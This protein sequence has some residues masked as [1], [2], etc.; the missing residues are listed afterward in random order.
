MPGYKVEITIPDFILA[1]SDGIALPGI[2][3]SRSHHEAMQKASSL[4]PGEYKLT[5]P[6]GTITVTHPEAIEPPV[7]PPIDPPVDPPV[8]PVDP[9]VEPPVS[10][11]GALIQDAVTPEHIAL[12]APITGDVPIDITARVEYRKAGVEAWVESTPLWRVRPDYI[13]STMESGF[14]GVI[15]DLDHDETYDVRVTFS[16]G[17]EQTLICQTRNLYRPHEVQQAYK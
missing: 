3:P 9:P 10:A 16:D 5:C 7:E 14:S 1:D 11:I 6:D 17:T 2:E 12:Y 13:D 15:F 4:P 8:D